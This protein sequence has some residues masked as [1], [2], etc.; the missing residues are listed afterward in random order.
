MHKAHQLVQTWEFQ[1]SPNSIECGSLHA[2]VPSAFNN[3]IIL[4]VVAIVRECVRAG[5]Q[6]GNRPGGCSLD[7]FSDA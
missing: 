5:G 3:N 1:H 7:E 6:A 2:N 4:H